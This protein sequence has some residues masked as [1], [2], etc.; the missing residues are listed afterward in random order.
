MALCLSPFPLFNK[1]TENIFFKAFFPV[2]K[3]APSSEGVERALS[4]PGSPTSLQGEFHSASLCDAYLPGYPGG[5]QRLWSLACL[6]RDACFWGR[7]QTLLTDLS[8]SFTFLLGWKVLFTVPWD[9]AVSCFLRWWPE[10][11]QVHSRM[12]GSF[13]YCAS[14]R[15]ERRRYELRFLTVCATLT[16]DNDHLKWL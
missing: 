1:E 9:K 11:C 8:N 14:L 12:I 6:H 4:A 3:I 13:W 7:P 2:W 5:L 10:V 15:V 16:T